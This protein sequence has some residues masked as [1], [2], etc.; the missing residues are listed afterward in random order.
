MPEDKA[1]FTSNNKC[2]RNGKRRKT[3]A[4]HNNFLLN[5]E[6]FMIIAE[7]R[8]SPLNRNVNWNKRS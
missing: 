3:V 2:A 4:G 1:F 7:P 8:A 6:N 5:L